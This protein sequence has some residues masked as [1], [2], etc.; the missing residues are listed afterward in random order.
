MQCP[1]DYPAV[2]VMI[3]QAAVVGRRVGIRPKRQDDWL[4]V[5]N[6]WGSVIGPPRVLK[7]PAIQEALTALQRLEYDSGRA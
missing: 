3:A 6:L 7:T 2:A 4:V 1:P 5:V